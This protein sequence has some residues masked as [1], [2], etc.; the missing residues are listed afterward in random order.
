M[1]IRR[2]LKLDS[3]NIKDLSSVEMELIVD[4][5]IRQYGQSPSVGLTINQGNGN[6]TSLSET[7]AIAGEGA[8]SGVGFPDAPASG[9]NVITY[10]NT[11][12]T[13]TDQTFPYRTGTGYE[14]YSYPIYRTASSNVRN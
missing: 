14:N 2:P 11:V 13:I 4:E 8:I 1:A 5:A 10:N 9:F 6:L 7:R 12:Q 3:G